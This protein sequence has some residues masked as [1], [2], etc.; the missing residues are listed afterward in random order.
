MTNLSS[1][2]SGNTGGSVLD[3]LGWTLQSVTDSGEAASLHM[4]AVLMLQKLMRLRP[5]WKSKRVLASVTAAEAS[6]LV[7]VTEPLHI[8]WD[9]DDLR[10][11]HFLDKVAQDMG[12]I[13][14]CLCVEWDYNNQEPRVSLW[15][16]IS[17]Q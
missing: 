6:G 7:G 13:P 3:R 15:R 9:D 8:P 16:T 14:W 2:K 11:L 4:Q 10:D 12:R 5:A 17:T 1:D